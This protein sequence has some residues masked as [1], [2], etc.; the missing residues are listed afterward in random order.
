[1]ADR[2]HNSQQ[3]TELLDSLRSPVQHEAGC[4]RAGRVTSGI[5]C[6]VTGQEEEMQGEG[7]KEGFSWSTPGERAGLLLPGHS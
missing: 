2:G 3:F 4:P 1:M 6:R 5:T 7:S